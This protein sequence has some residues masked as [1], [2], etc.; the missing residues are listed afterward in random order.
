[1]LASREINKV[2]ATDMDASVSSAIV[3]Q[4]EENTKDMPTTEELGQ[5]MLEERPIPKYN[6]DAATVEEVYKR[7]DL[8]TEED[9]EGLWITDWVKNG[10]AETKSTHVNKRVAALM[11]DT[12]KRHTRELKILKYIASLIEFYVFQQNGKNRLPPLSKTKSAFYGTSPIVVEGF[13]RRFAEVRSGTQAK[14]KAERYTVSP[15]LESKLLYYLAVLCLMV[16]R[17]DVDLFD[18][19]HDLNIMPRELAEAFKQVGCSIRELG[20]H[21]IEVMKI[22][23][24]EAMQHKRAVLKVPLEFPPPPRR[25]MAK[26][27]RR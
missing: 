26:D 27:K 23:K 11:E 19:K 13:Y 24:A 18:L 15:R 8:I 22:T 21:Q 10:G 7:E 5:V 25:R 6:L 9:W 3:S 17:Y 1:M 16:D 2:D 12:S 20:K 4:V 14:D